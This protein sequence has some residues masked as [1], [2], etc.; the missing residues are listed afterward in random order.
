MYPEKLVEGIDPKDPPRLD[1]HHKKFYALLAARGVDVV[2]LYPVLAAERKGPKGPAYCRTDT[3]WSG[4]ACVLAAETLAKRIKRKDWYE[5]ARKSTYATEERE[6]TIAGDLTRGLPA[7]KKPGKET[8][9]LRFVGTKGGRGLAPVAPDANSPVVL[10]ADSHGLVFHAGEDMHCK[11]AGLADQLAYELGF[12]VDLVAARG[13]AATPVRMT[14][15]RSGLKP[16]YLDKKKVV[17]WC[18]AAR[19]FT[20]TMGWSKVP[21]KIETE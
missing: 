17:I 14:F 2:D 12:P 6:V 10:M 21:V 4:R 20:E 18:V 13:S 8:L 15:C 5:G 1:L 9:T 19:E 16:G 11:G 7:G 3:H